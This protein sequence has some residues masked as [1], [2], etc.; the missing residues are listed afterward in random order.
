[1]GQVQGQVAKD[2]AIYRAWVDGAR[3]T[4]LA[5]QYGVTQQAISQ[6][7]GRVL[8]AYP[9]PDK[10]QEVRRTLDLVDDL[11]QVYVPKAR[12][13]N[14]AYNREVRGLLALKGRYLGIDRREVDVT[15]SG[16][17]EHTWEPGPTVAEVLERWREQGLLRPQAELERLDQEPTL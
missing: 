10:V 5:T 17:V 7:V 3:Q 1:M 16:Q 6:A 12:D 11:I 2:V 8:D 13:G 4:D 14:T 15:V 9:E